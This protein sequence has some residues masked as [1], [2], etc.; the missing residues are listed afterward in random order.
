MTVPRCRR[1]ETHVPCV[2]A[3]VSLQYMECQPTDWSY[4]EGRSTGE[5]LSACWHK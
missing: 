1:V 4:E 2:L 3:E 5:G